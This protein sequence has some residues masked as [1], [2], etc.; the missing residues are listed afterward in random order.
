[1]CTVASTV[2]APRSAD[3]PG[4][5]SAPADSRTAHPA[6]L[7]RRLPH[8]LHAAR[9]A[10]G[11]VLDFLR[12][13]GQEIV[14]DAAHLVVSELVANAVRHGRP[15]V[16]LT[17]TWWDDRARRP[18][19]LV[20]V[21]DRGTPVLLGPSTRV[22]DAEAEG[23]RGLMLVEACSDRWGVCHHDGAGL[24]VW[25]EIDRPGAAR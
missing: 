13:L 12:D 3:R 17:L 25:A 7:S 19:L 24:H 5:G 1:M 22:G 23:G 2:I 18:G 21:L 10:R 15:P 11:V 16:D 6:R 8:T 9:N 4:T 14:G 20:E